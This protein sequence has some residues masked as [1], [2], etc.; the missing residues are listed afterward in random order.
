MEIWKFNHPEPLRPFLRVLHNNAPHLVNGARRLFSSA[1]EAKREDLVCLAKG[2]IDTSPEV[3]EAVQ[4]LIFSPP[5]EDEVNHFVRL[6]RW[7]P[8][9]LPS[10]WYEHDKVRQAVAELLCCLENPQGCR[11]LATLLEVLLKRSSFVSHQECIILSGP[12]NSASRRW[13]LSFLARRLS[14]PIRRGLINRLFAEET[15]SP[16]E[17]CAALIASNK[18]SPTGTLRYWGKTTSVKALATCAKAN[19]HSAETRGLDKSLRILSWGQRSK[20]EIDFLEK[21]ISY[22]VKELSEVFR[23]ALEVSR[24]TN[25]V[26]IT[27]HNASLG[28]ATGWGAPSLAHQISARSAFEFSQ[29]VTSLRR[30]FIAELSN[31]QKSSPFPPGYSVKEHTENLFDLWRKRLVRPYILQNLWTLRA[32]L[33]LNSIPLDQWE[34]F[35]DQAKEILQPGDHQRLTEGKGFGLA[36]VSATVA[37][38]QL[39]QTLSW[40][41]KQRLGHPEKLCLLWALIGTGQQWLSNG[42]LEYLVLPLVDKFFI[43]S[44][45]DQDL[46]YLPS[47][48]KLVRRFDHTPLFLLIDDTSRA[49]QPSLQLAID[50]WRKNYPFLGL[51]VFAGKRDSSLSYLETIL[52]NSSKINLFALRPLT[53]VHN[54]AALDSLLAQGP[55]EFFT[56]EKYDASWKDNLPFLYQGT[57]IAPFA[58]GVEHPQSFSPFVHTSAGP[59]FFGTYYRFKLRKQALKDLGFTEE[60][61]Q[62]SPPQSQLETLWNE[63]ADLANLL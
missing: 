60:K 13:L 46:D 3:R 21:L 6:L 63:Y 18:L 26:V 7:L 27:L 14:Y 29:E 38:R 5:I 12:L 36:F 55:T 43:S 35:L 9:W 39:K 17:I 40:Y 54:P 4:V 53:Q 57:Q 28:A 51:G 62:F 16:A 34:Q 8:D 45:R 61:N 11:P 58:G 1:R 49:S 20:V 23:L 30:N 48:L 47:F 15:L 44:K 24:R 25:R 32:S 42:R 50:R 22:Q 33:L 31:R 2:L 59:M 56:P 10:K 52:D 19:L 41:R 37:R